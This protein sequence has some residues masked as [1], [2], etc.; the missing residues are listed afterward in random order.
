MKR[1]L[2]AALSLS[3]FCNA[4]FGDISGVD[5]QEETDYSLSPFYFAFGAGT[6]GYEANIKN[7]KQEHI[8]HLF[9]A[10]V[11]DFY[12]Q[13]NSLGFGVKLSPLV[14][15]SGYKETDEKGRYKGLSP[16]NAELFWSPWRMYDGI[17]AGPFVSMNYLF[18]D[19]NDF[20]FRSGVKLA[21]FK[22]KELNSYAN[23]VLNWTTIEAGYSRI[24][25]TNNYYFNINIDV[26]EA[27]Y[28]VIGFFTLI[29]LAAI[30]SK[31][32]DSEYQDEPEP[33]PKIK[34]PK[35]KHRSTNKSEPGNA[36][37]RPSGKH[38]K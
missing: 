14:F 15:L 33:A 1:I 35:K 20:A 27:A 37:S 28:A 26:V 12:M 3:L 16:F 21:L 34:E 32:N 9:K 18:S 23:Y 8:L 31:N 36:P 2:A 6:V 24:D 25:N 17:I 4:A 19:K 5:G 22:Q 7:T 13:E 10:S 30:A 11:L 38:K 29:L